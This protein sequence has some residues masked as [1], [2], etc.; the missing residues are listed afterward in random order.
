MTAR[1]GYRLA[2]GWA[3]GQPWRPREI[4]LILMYHAVLDADEDPHQLAVS[5]TKFTAQM[6]ALA[7]LGL[8]GVGI[9]ELCAAMQAGQARGMVGITFDDGYR[10]VLDAALPVLRG[11]GFGATVFV[12]SGRIGGANDWDAGPVWPLLGT[13]GIAELAAAGIEIGSHS[14]THV[15]MAGLD[16]ASLAAEAGQSRAELSELTGAAIGGFAYPYGS[17]DDAAVAAVGAAGYSYACAVTAPRASVGPMAMPRMY[18]GE[19]DG[20]AR[21]LAKRLLYRSHVTTREGTS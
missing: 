5:P 8:R 7:R 2:T 12:I 6:A 21:M 11:R 18:V 13:S 3:G 4:P 20:L 15:R 14:V 9:A 17:L 16:S 10:S 1:S 19:R